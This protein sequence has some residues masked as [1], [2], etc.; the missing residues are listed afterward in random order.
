M[1]FKTT[2]ET[3]SFIPENKKE[4]YFLGTTF[5]KSSNNMYSL[6]FVNGELEFVTI[7]LNDILEMLGDS[8]N[9]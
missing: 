2:K 1:K 8:K 5:N 4:S 9:E 3:I 6:N 7:K